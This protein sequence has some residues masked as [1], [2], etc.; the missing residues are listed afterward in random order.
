MGNGDGLGHGRLLR[1]HD[2]ISMAYDRGFDQVSAKD[3][4]TEF[5]ETKETSQFCVTLADDTVAPN[6]ASREFGGH[7]SVTASGVVQA[8]SSE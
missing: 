4:H 1:N 8:S 6:D 2:A 7:R 3:Y 5:V